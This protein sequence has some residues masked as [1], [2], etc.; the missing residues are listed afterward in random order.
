P[1]LRRQLNLGTQFIP[2]TALAK[3][4]ALSD[5]IVNEFRQQFR[6]RQQGQM[7]YSDQST[8]VRFIGETLFKSDILFPDSIRPGEY[9]A[10]VYLVDG[11]GVAASQSIPIRVRKRG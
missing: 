10:D 4:E 5:D 1:E 2:M 11:T 9:I 8:P 7:L 3:D 6:T